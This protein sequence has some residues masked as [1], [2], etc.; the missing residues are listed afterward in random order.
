MGGGRV[1]VCC[2]FWL[3]GPEE[4]IKSYEP[5]SACKNMKKNTKKYGSKITKWMKKVKTNMANM[6]I[7]QF[8]EKARG[9]DKKL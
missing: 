4:A 8:K 7:L 5:A 9:S 2:L 3:L 6:A 1:E